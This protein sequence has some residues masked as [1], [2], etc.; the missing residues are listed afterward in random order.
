LD[1]H[2]LRGAFD[3]ADAAREHGCFDSGELTAYAA[4]PGCLRPKAK[5]IGFISKMMITLRMRSFG[6]HPHTRIV[7][8]SDL[9]VILIADATWQD[10]R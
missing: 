5:L 3:E 4:G 10:R 7:V 6:L 9:I 1:I 8:A 2:H